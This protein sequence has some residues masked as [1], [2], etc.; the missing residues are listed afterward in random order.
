[1]TSKMIGSN[2]KRLLIRL[3]SYC[4]FLSLHS[5]CVHSLLI[6]SSVSLCRSE[7]FSRHFNFNYQSQQ[8]SG[9]TH[10]QSL[11]P[12]YCFVCFLRFYYIFFC[13]TD[14]YFYGPYHV[15][16]RYLKSFIYALDDDIVCKWHARSWMHHHDLFLIKSKTSSLFSVFLSISFCLLPNCGWKSAILLS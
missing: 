16:R 6:V 2:R 11:P 12:R 8:T 15:G 14:V 9:S 4:P 7:S 1:M 3:V 13:C 5:V 10:W